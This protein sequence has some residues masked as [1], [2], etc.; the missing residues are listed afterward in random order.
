MIVPLLEEEE[1]I[2]NYLDTN[3]IDWG[4]EL[5]DNAPKEAIDALNSY[6]SR[7]NNLK[8]NQKVEQS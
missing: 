6:L 3:N 4:I 8:Q 5:V 1:I 2:L 7:Y